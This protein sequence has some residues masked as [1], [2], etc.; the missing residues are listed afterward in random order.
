MALKFIAQLQGP[1]N[2]NQQL[3]NN[4]YN[5]TKIAIFAPVGH[6]CY[7]NDILFEIGKTGMLEI[8]DSTIKSITFLQDEDLNT[9]IDYM[10]ED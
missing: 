7:I 5:I 4:N 6:Y 1:F 2:A 3:L 9:F 10:Y 8:R